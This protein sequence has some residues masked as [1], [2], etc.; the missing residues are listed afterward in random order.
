MLD[1][2]NYIARDNQAAA[3]AALAHIRQRATGFAIIVL[4]IAFAAC[5]Q[6]YPVKPIRLISPFSPGG[7]TDVLGRIVG[8]KLNDRMG[9]P[10]VVENAST[11][12]P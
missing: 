7:A 2:E 8:Q 1:I 10:V 9:Q 11:D 5:A 3:D 6:D 4:C 12:S